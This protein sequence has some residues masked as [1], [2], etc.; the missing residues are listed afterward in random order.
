MKKRIPRP[1][2]PLKDAQKTFEAE[3]GEHCPANGWWAPVDREGEGHFI[4][5]GSIMPPDKGQPITWALVSGDLS[6]SKPKH[7][8][9]PAGAFLD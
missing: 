3:T 6:P 4:V 9:P 7:A 5:E 1:H 2:I 8:H